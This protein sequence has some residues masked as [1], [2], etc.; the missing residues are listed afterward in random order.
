MRKGYSSGNINRLST[1]YNV[2]SL[3]AA[4]RNLSNM[5]GGNGDKSSILPFEISSLSFVLG[6][7]SR[8]EQSTIESFGKDVHSV[9]LISTNTVEGLAAFLFSIFVVV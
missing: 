9:S 2:L 5:L 8:H 7:T 6:H 3:P 1:V 4:S